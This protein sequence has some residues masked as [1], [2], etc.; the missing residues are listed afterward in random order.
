MTSRKHL[1]TKVTPD[2]HHTTIHI[3]ENVRIKMIKRDNFSMFLL[4]NHLH[5]RAYKP[6]KYVYKHDVEIE[7]LCDRKQTDNEGFYDE[8]LTEKRGDSGEECNTRF[9][10]ARHCKRIVNGPT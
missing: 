4:H 6:K 9:Y 5:N 2:L 10:I 7:E 8:L 3:A 1:R